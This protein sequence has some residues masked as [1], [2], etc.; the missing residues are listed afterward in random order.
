VQLLL[1]ALATAGWTRERCAERVGIA[2]ADLDAGGQIQMRHAAALL[3]V[4]LEIGGP[5]FAEA[6][7]RIPSGA[8]GLLDHLCGAAPTAR[9]AL[10][11]LARYFRLVSFGAELELRDE[12][13]H[14]MLPPN[15]PAHH[16]QLLQDLFFTFLVERLRARTELEAARAGPTTLKF[17][18]RDLDRSL[19]ADTSLR[20]LLDGYAARELE[21][22]PDATT[23]ATQVRR[24][25]LAALPGPTPSAGEVARALAMSERSLRRALQ[26]EGQ[27]FSGVR[28]AALRWFAE[29]ALGDASRTVGEVAWMLGYSEPSAFHRAFR[30]W[31]GTSPDQFRRAGQNGH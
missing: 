18:A 5:D 27:T 23:T 22:Q 26:E 1:A 17:R 4:A 28:D 2:A 21:A 13:L 11:D 7:R 15:V 20:E 30:R 24:V 29:Q 12:S 31:T 9:A 3:D 16:A 10:Q 19:V 6:G 14:L 25:L 8:M